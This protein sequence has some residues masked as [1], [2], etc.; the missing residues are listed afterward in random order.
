MGWFGY[1]KY[2]GDETQTHHLDFIKWAKLP[3]TDEE[4]SDCLLINKTKI[5]KN[6]I[7]L[8]NKNL[9]NILKNMNSN[10]KW[11]EEN[12]IQWQMLMLLLLDNNIKLPKIIK[13]NGILAT[14]FLMGQHSTEFNKPSARRAVLQKILKKAN[15]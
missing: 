15:Q 8:F 4:I 2:S 14:K 6:L 13:N 12:A 5:P 1:G 7:S 9:P 11:D 3:L 10:K